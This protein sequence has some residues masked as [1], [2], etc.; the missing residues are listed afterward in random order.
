L[1]GDIPVLRVDQS[2]TGDMTWYNEESLPFVHCAPTAFAQA[3][4]VFLA[5]FGEVGVLVEGDA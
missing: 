1:D 5:A 4:R 2:L 3:H